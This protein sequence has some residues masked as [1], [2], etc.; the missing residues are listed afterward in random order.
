MEAAIFILFISAWQAGAC[1]VQPA[2]VGFSGTPFSSHPLQVADQ[3]VY[4]FRGDAREISFHYDL[5]REKWCYSG[6]EAEANC[7]EKDK[8]IL[9]GTDGKPA[10]RISAGQRRLVADVYDQR[11]KDSGKRIVIKAESDALE[12]RGWNCPVSRS[13]SCAG[14]ELKTYADQPN[15]EAAP[16]PSIKSVDLSKRLAHY[17]VTCSGIHELN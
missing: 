10:A 14:A 12:V 4:F 1:E 2:H 13:I 15:E 11:G 9:R 7:L 5:R 8:L 6:R 16:R 17:S 3:Q